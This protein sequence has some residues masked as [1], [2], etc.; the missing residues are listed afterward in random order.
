[1]AILAADPDVSRLVVSG[2]WAKLSRSVRVFLTPLGVITVNPCCPFA[3][4]I[5]AICGYMRMR[6]M[7]EGANDSSLL[8]PRITLRARSVLP[9]PP[10]EPV[11][12]PS[13]VMR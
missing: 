13:S 12:R 6:Q 1:M 7:N 2:L 4:I 9:P 8:Y 3:L 11:N 10:L 5:A